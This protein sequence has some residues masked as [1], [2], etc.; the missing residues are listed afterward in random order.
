MSIFSKFKLSGADRVLDAR[1]KIT[2]AIEAAKE[3]LLAA[4]PEQFAAEVALR[5]AEASNA[6]GEPVDLESVHRRVTAAAA[7]IEQRSTVLSGLRYR[8]AALA[9]ETDAQYQALKASL[10]DHVQRV[11]DDFAS[12][13]AKGVSAWSALL[14]R[15]AAIETL[16]GSRL[17]LPDPEPI[18]A[19]LPAELS[20]PWR[21][22]DALSAAIS[23]IAGLGSWVDMLAVDRMMPRGHRPYDRTAI[24]SITG[25][26]ASLERGT[27]VVDGVFPE[28]MLEH[29]HNLGDAEIAT[30]QAWKSGLEAGQRAA[31]RVSAEK[32]REQQAREDAREAKSVGTYDPAKAAAASREQ[33]QPVTDLTPHVGA[34]GN[35]WRRETPRKVVGGA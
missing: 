4:I 10:P 20:A 3:K 32:Q 5:D 35:E 25:G 28:G 34:P 16:I 22:A 23:E 2:A 19:E 1:N 18:A 29:L 12:D 13:W 27:L 21:A 11:R 31:Q 14:G 6:L 26:A 9:G 8:L 15:R 24:Y 33:Q 30:L 7:S 17:T